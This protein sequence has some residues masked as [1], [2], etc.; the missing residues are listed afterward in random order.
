MPVSGKFGQAA[1]RSSEAASH[2]DHHCGL[3]CNVTL[4]SSKWWRQS[5]EVSIRRNEAMKEQVGGANKGKGQ[6]WWKSWA[7]DAAKERGLQERYTSGQEEKFVCLAC[8]WQALVRAA[9]IEF[10]FK[11]NEVHWVS[12]W[13]Q[14]AWL[15]R[16]H[17]I[18]CL[19]ATQGT[20]ASCRVSRRDIKASALEE[21][22]DATAT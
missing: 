10:R 1:G 22:K 15:A 9:Q 12:K 8:V 2:H 7:V 17:L 21:M 19:Q 4:T 6:R 11:S 18:D 13:L 14:L 3:Q 5:E 20:T 16:P